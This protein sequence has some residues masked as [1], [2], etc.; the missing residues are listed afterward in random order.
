[1]KFAKD[2]AFGALYLVSGIYSVGFSLV[3]S[4]VAQPLSGKTAYIPVPDGL[5]PVEVVMFTLFG[6]VFFAASLYHFRITYHVL[7]DGHAP[8]KQ[9][10]S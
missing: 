5:F 9:D 6:A 8:M 7:S 4:G 2:F 1:M 3:I 10:L